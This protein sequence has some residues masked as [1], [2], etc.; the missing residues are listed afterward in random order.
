M[1]GMTTKERK[2][3]GRG[4]NALLK[5]VDD[6]NKPANTADVQQISIDDICLNPKQP[7]QTFN[8]EKL[9][10]L[11]QSIRIK[12]V[13]QPILVRK[14][15][16][17]PKDFELI[18][19]ERRLRASKLAGFDKVPALIKQIRD[20][21]LLEVALIENI[22]RDNLNPI[23]ESLAYRNLIDEHGYTQEDLAK[24]VGKN[25]STV[26]NMLRLL[27]LPEEIKTEIAAEKLSVGHARTI[28]SLENKDDQIRLK[29]QVLS[30][31]ISVRDTEKIVKENKTGKKPKTVKSNTGSSSEDVQM[32]M[33]QDRLSE[34]LS[35]K[36]VIRPNGKK[37]K[38]ELEYY[39]NEDFNRIF[40]LI[41]K[42]VH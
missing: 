7:R 2:A 11:A 23:E 42:T 18:A 19:G 41:L 33:N 26:A 3:L 29:D 13:L 40:N 12:G 1:Q 10:E 31:N 27:Q 28:L 4:F 38:I 17:A 8:D 9:K 39:D 16:S 6:F 35:T 32:N 20:E 37:G 14:V 30:N 15:D 34:F 24:R 21:D 22:Q 25:R 36:V 5:S